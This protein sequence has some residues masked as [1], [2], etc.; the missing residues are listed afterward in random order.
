M[1]CVVHARRGPRAAAA[2]GAPRFAET[3]PP[4]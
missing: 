1:Q 3:Q 2:S 4:A